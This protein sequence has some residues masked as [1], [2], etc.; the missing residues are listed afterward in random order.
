MF[1]PSSQKGARCFGL[2][3]CI[4]PALLCQGWPQGVIFLSPFFPPCFYPFSSLQGV[5]F[6]PHFFHLVFT[7][8]LLCKVLSFIFFHLVFTLKV[9]SFIPIFSTLFSPS[10]CYLLSPFFPPCFYSFF[11]FARCSWCAT[12]RW[13]RTWSR[14]SRFTTKGDI[15]RTKTTFSNSQDQQAGNRCGITDS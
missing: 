12:A 3:H 2:P 15:L 14:G 7:L 4:S 10:R 6:Y 1:S 8:F 5:I 13:Q 9:L 11:F